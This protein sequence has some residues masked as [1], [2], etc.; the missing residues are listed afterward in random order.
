MAKSELK[1][2][3]RQAIREAYDKALEQWKIPER[4]YYAAFNKKTLEF[5]D[6]DKT[7]EGLYNKLDEKLGSDRDSTYFTSGLPPEQRRGPGPRTRANQK[8]I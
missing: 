1:E 2:E 3:T 7:W 8:L 6:V 5:I 4:G